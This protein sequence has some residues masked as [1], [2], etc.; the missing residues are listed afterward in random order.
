MSK[1]IIA[2]TMGDPA[3][4]GPEVIIKALSDNE[5]RGMGRFLVFGDANILHREA[6]NLGFNIPLIPIP[7]TDQAGFPSNAVEIVNLSILSPTFEYGRPSASSGDAAFKYIKTAI[8]SALER[9]VDA[10][11]T[12]PI[13]KE[14]LNMAGHSYPGHTEILAELCNTSDYA[15]MLAGPHLRV[16]LCTIHVPYTRV[17][18]L[19]SKELILKTIRITHESLSKYLGKKPRIA[20][21]SLN[22]HAGEGGMFGGE[23]KEL[24]IPAVEEA[25]NK[26]ID[27]SGPHP[28]DTLFYW[29]SK[30]KYDAVVCMYHD[31]GLI[32][33]KLLDF[34]RGVNVTLGLSIIRTSV[35]H[36]TAF[37]IAGKGVA[38]PSSMKEAIRM[39]VEMGTKGGPTSSV[40]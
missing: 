30:G 39:A 33:L 24:I 1:A 13:S 27:A 3:G 18:S 38:D 11:V 5:V 21:A 29:A 4:I 22:P 16:V 9:K 25:F 23:E 19:L 26:G 20:V 6:K 2:I 40:M 12:A 14:A 17:P 28:P 15:M 35:D 37:D 8:L 36:G 10:I 31:Q 32:P 7:D 34:E